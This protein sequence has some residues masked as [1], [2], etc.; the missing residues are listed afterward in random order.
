MKIVSPDILHKTEIGGV[1]LNVDSTDAC[2]A[3]YQTLIERAGVKAPHAHIEGV[4]VTPMAPKGIETIMGVN[5]DPV[6]G[7][8]VM[9][10]L[11]GI[12]TELFEDVTFRIAPFDEHEA[13]LMIEETKG[14]G[15]LKGFRGKPAA[16]IDALAKTLAQLSQFAAANAD[17]IS[18]IDLN[19]VVALEAGRGVFALDAVIVP[20]VQ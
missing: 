13:R 18:S 8:V 19:P 20:G 1:I 3:A 17:Q 16:D 7:P 10:G 9:F 5:R 6:F 11:G 15:L 4:L 14:Y 12:F 2:R